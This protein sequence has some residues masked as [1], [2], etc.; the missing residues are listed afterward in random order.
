[1]MMTMND[2]E[3][4]SGVDDDDEGGLRGQVGVRAVDDE[5]QGRQGDDR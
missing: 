1:M 4:R 5:V 2:D 3:V